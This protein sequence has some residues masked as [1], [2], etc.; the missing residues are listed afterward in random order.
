MAIHVIMNCMHR[1]KNKEQ[2]S[3]QEKANKPIGVNFELPELKERVTDALLSKGGARGN[4]M[5]NKDGLNAQQELFCE[6]FTRKVGY[7][8]NGTQSYIKAY[9]INVGNDK[10]VGQ[11]SYG[12]C[13]VMASDLLTKPNILRRIN[14][15]IEADGFNDKF[16]EKQL[17]FLAMQNVDFKVK[18][19]AVN[20]Y[21]TLK[22]RIG[23]KNNYPQ[24]MLGI[25]KHVYS[26]M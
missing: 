2:S 16:M 3:L 15:L 19:S 23:G 6:L 11:T 1:A 26:G 10:K 18:L 7:F 22:E 5:V 21:N 13:R 17:M 12:T 20:F 24:E 25:V 14:Q 9:G 8:S 4:R